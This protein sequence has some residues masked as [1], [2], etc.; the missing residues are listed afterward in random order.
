MNT[1][2]KPCPFCGG[3]AEAMSNQECTDNGFS[4]N[5]MS[6]DFIYCQCC[7]ATVGGDTLE[8]VVGLWNRRVNEPK[9]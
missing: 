8:D 9:N 2:L 4:F 5:G 6:A 3:E 1:D 7:A